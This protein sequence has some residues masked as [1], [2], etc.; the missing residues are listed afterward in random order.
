MILTI[1]SIKK[2]RS[3][4]GGWY[5]HI[6][7]KSIDGKKNYFSYIYE[8]MKNFHRWKKVMDVNTTLSN[9]KLVKGKDKLVDADSRF[10]LVE[11]KD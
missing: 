7:F 10:V 5:Y 1:A 3:R 9:L 11:N 8:K 4:Y 2:K 6:S